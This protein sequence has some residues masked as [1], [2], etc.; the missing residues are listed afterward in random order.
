MSSECAAEVSHVPEGI[1]S[2]SEVVDEPI[3][4]SKESTTVASAVGD[5][6]PG[7]QKNV[8]P[9]L[10]PEPEGAFH[11]DDASSS[12]GIMWSFYNDVALRLALASKHAKPIYKAVIQP[13]VLVLTAVSLAIG[14]A[15]NFKL[16][17][18]QSSVSELSR[19][20]SSNSCVPMCTGTTTS[21]ATV[22]LAITTTKTITRVMVKYTTRLVTEC[23]TAVS[24]V[25]S[26]ASDYYT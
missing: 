4:Q 18:V 25:T 12:K 11:A 6:V 1:V 17:N 24:T 16:S 2:N 8:P 22:I 7:I 26:S 5:I 9:Q 21:T 3:E 15:L 13:V 23:A 20:V 14:I 19:A 10:R